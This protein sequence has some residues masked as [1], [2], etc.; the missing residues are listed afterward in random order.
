MFSVLSCVSKLHVTTIERLQ[1]QSKMFSVLHVIMAMP[2]SY[3]Y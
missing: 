1:K 3:T 2:F